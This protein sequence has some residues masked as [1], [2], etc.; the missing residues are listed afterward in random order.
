MQWIFRSPSLY[1]RLRDHNTDNLIKKSNL[2]FRVCLDY[3]LDVCITLTAPLAF[4]L[5]D[6]PLSMDDAD[7]EE[8]QK[9]KKVSS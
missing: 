8:K 6:V 4:R 1:V 7:S 9:E 5:V 3:N 2:A